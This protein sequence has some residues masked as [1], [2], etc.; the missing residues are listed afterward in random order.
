MN[1][2][3]FL[4]GFLRHVLQKRCRGDKDVVPDPE[5]SNMRRNHWVVGN[6]ASICWHTRQFIDV[7][8]LLKKRALIHASVTPQTSKIIPNTSGF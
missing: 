3:D 2:F 8:F 7:C 5:V 6:M 4:W 1:L